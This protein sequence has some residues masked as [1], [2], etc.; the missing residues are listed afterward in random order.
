VTSR[1]IAERRLANQRITR[2]KRCQPSDLVEWLGA[3]QAQEYPHARWA[4]GLRM[5]EGASD[6]DVERACEAG[7]ILRTHVM[8][9]TWH[10]VTPADIH[11]ML[12]L[13]APRV[14]RAMSTYFRQQGLDAPMLARCLAVFERA[15]AEDAVLTRPELGVRL[16][17][18][19]VSAQGMRLAL[20]TM[21]A[22]LERVIVSGPRRGNALTYALLT[23]RAL[24][25]RRLSRNEAL[26]E[27]TRR[28]FASHGP[29]TVRDFVWWSGLLTADAKHGLDM[30]GAKSEVIGDLT[31]WTVGRQAAG[32]K[33]APLVHLLPIYDEY[34]VAYRDRV[35]V[36]QLGTTVPSTS[37]GP[38]TFQHALIASGQ[39]AGT[40]RTGRKGGQVTV[41]VIPIRRLT[42]S[43]RSALDE[44]A[45]RYSRFL[46][47]EIALT[48]RT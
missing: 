33:D 25:P 37:R 28:Y 8:R 26:A 1:S 14:R 12:E 27:L 44:A 31:Y 5:P 6:P 34:I 36:P 18:A 43:E 11:W 35:G 17:R 13:T 24:K 29:A 41:D 23:L 46:G 2:P 47:A 32:M 9:P 40:W 15:L 22:E 7:A 39:V 48:V 21:H 20:I 10:F 19:G 3:V 30:I 16:A 42:K 38:V 4:L 45:A